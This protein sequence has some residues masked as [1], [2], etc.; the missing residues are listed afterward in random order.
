M[1]L[2]GKTPRLQVDNFLSLLVK[3]Y[4]DDDPTMLV[5]WLIE[6]CS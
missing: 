2:I 1:I 3:V 5:E 4:D 6:K